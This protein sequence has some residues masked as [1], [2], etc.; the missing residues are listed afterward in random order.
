[1]AERRPPK[2]PSHLR[3]FAE[4]GTDATLAS[5]RA[6]TEAPRDFLVAGARMLPLS[7]V[8]PNILQPRTRFD[9]D[10]L[11]ELAAD[12]AAH[13]VLQPPIVRPRPQ[14]GY[15]IV[16]G[17]RRYRAARL[18]GLQTIPVLV[19]ELSD[20]EARII[21]LVENLQ[22]ENLSAADERA[23]LL[24]LS[25]EGGLSTRQISALIHRSHMYVQR[26]LQLEEAGLGE[27][28]DRG[29]VTLEDTALT[30]EQAQELPPLSVDDG[31]GEGAPGRRGRRAVDALR[32]YE[33]LTA[34]ARRT[35]FRALPDRRRAREVL[36]EAIDA[37]RRAL[38]QLEAGD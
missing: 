10:L 28:Y 4:P 2:G 38:D 21:S 9:A 30:R 24:R 11:D 37:L 16:A 8:F 12:I 36:G 31:A 35:D 27:Q 32:P 3:A 1:M 19:R 15:E 14:G 18:A 34:V 23:F 7:D 20:D 25:E 5:L 26:R 13:G 6:L 29:E 33:R 17:E 22:R